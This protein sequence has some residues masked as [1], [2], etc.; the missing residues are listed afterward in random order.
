MSCGPTPHRWAPRVGHFDL[1]TLFM[2]SL[3]VTAVAMVIA[4]PLGLAAAAYLAEYANPRVRRILKPILEVLAGIPSIV[5]AFFAI[6]W[7]GPEI[8][9]QLFADAEAFSLAA[10]GIG[11]GILVTP[12][13]GVGQR[14]RHARGAPCA[15][16]GEL[17]H[18][19]AQDHD[20]DPRR[21]PGRDLRHRR[22]RDPRRFPCHR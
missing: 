19:R 20:R 13:G 10:A 1:L 11:V 17:R 16:R 21:V 9:E 5:L 8:V 15:A 2:G 6:E 18:G 12:L 4:I 7:I 22:R 14:G 3:L